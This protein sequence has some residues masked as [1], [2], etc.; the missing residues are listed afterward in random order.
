MKCRAFPGG[1]PDVILENQ[2]DH[3]SPVEGDHGIRFDPTT[4]ADGAYARD[5]FG[6]DRGVAE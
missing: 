5:L 2:I 1:I 6:R 4:P 3:R